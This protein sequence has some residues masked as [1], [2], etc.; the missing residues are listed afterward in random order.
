MGKLGEGLFRTSTLFSGPPN[1]GTGARTF[2]DVLAGTGSLVTLSHTFSQIGVPIGY[3]SDSPLGIST[4]FFDNTNLAM[5]GIMLGTYKYTWGTGA[6]QSF[7]IDV[8][9]TTAPPTPLPAALPLFATGL[10]GLGLL[11]W[12]RK[13]KAVT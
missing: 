13:R 2:G 4:A 1:F 7:E 9:A 12:R 10:G 8:V 11:G 5:L 6:D 3:V